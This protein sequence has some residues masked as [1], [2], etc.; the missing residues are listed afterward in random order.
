M[1]AYFSDSYRADMSAYT[2]NQIAQIASVNPEMAAT[3]HARYT[4]A[5]KSGDA[6]Q[7]MAI[8]LRVERSYN[9]ELSRM[10][11]TTPIA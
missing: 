11:R 10:Y 1:L 9:D 3:L 4:A 6:D 5:L 8:G 2:F 7:E